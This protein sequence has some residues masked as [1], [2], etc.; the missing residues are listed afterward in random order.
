MGEVSELVPL[1]FHYNPE[2]KIHCPVIFK[3]FTNASHVVANLASGHV[4][5]YEAVLELNK[6]Q[7]NFTDLITNKPFKWSDIVVL[8]D[9]DKMEDRTVDKFYFMQKGQQEEVVRTITHK[10]SEEAKELK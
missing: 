4:Y 1:N 6:K 2:G 3:A 10:E 7:K 9:P 8:Q 5:S